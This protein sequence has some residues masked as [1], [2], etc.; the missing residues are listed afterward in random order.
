MAVS[1]LGF[2]VFGVVLEVIF[3]FVVELET[4][5]AVVGVRSVVL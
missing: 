4:F 2:V 5:R 1:L 3:V